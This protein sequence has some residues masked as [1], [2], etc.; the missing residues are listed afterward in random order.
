MLSECPALHAQVA[1]QIVDGLAVIVL[2][3][4][5][6]V[7]A[8]GAAHVPANQNWQVARLRTFA[9]DGERHPLKRLHDKIRDHPAII[10]RHAR[11]I[12]VKDAHHP[13]VDTV[14]AAIIKTQ[15]LGG[16]LAL[17]VAGAQARAVD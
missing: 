11:P 16:A 9:I 7:L 4:S 2:A 1:M 12:G 5:G 3:D 13:H 8:S 10:A 15:R 17:I 6:E 14:A